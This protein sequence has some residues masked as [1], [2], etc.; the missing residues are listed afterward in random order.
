MNTFGPVIAAAGFIG[1]VQA[2]SVYAPVT[3][4]MNIENVDRAEATVQGR[5]FGRKIKDC[6]VVKDSFVGWQMVNDIW[7]ET[8]FQFVDDPS[9]NSTRPDGWAVQDFG[10]W[11]WDDVAPAATDVKMTLQ[12]NCGGRLEVT[13][14]S[15]S[16][17]GT[18]VIE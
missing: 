13:Q 4:S 11:R 18:L 9:P 8:P 3:V 15:F 17:S 12:H 14:A 16:I 7:Y 2:F 1:F 6:A 5:V 10:V